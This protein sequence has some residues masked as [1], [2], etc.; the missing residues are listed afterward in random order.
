MLGW[1]NVSHQTQNLYI[2]GNNS[3]ALPP[4]SDVRF[5]YSS[6]GKNGYILSDN[7]NMSKLLQLI[8]KLQSSGIGRHIINMTFWKNP[9]P[10][11]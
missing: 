7:Q 5:F 2:F 10:Q 4:N 9:L 3:A 1:E 11:K 8:S 6:K